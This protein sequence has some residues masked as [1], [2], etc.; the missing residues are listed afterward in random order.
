MI[1]AIKK[2]LNKSNMIKLKNILHD[3]KKELFIF[4]NVLL[5]INVV[6]IISH[7]DVDI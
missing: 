2:N 5:K 6:N 1:V 7:I 3:E 4:E